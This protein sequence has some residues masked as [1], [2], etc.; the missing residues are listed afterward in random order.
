MTS[1]ECFLPDPLFF[2]LARNRSIIRLCDEIASAT[3]FEH[4]HIHVFA[5]AEIVRSGARL[6][7]FDGNVCF[8]SSTTARKDNLR[9]AI[10]LESLTAGY[11][12]CSTVGLVEGFSKTLLG[13]PLA[14][15]IATAKRIRAKLLKT[16]ESEIVELIVKRLTSEGAKITEQEFIAV[17]Q[18]VA[19]WLSASRALALL[20]GV[21][22]NRR[23][24]GAPLERERASSE[25]LECVSLTELRRLAARTGK[26]T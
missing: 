2:S 5:A 10:W 26:D 15:D 14:T 9:A 8:E 13:F 17:C 6:F 21:P 20:K 23:F 4:A 3:G 16:S 11:F 12:T 25:L 1:R 7:A 19:R 22:R 24:A 18:N